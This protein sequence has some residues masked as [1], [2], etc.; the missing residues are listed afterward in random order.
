MS[1]LYKSLFE[2]LP[3][4]DD[5]LV[6]LLEAAEKAEKLEVKKIPLQ[7]ALDGLGLKGEITITAD[8]AQ[9]VFDDDTAYHAAC[10]LLGTMDTITQLCGQGWVPIISGDTRPGDESPHY[11]ISFLEVDDPAANKENATDAPSTEDLATTAM[12]FNGFADPKTK[13]VEPKMQGKNPRGVIGKK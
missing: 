6:K 9:L 2:D 7:K 11:I 5:E 8:G 4:P 12:K 1:D 3:E 13:P 10:H